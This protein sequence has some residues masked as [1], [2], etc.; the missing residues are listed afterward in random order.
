ME[1]TITLWRELPR[2]VIFTLVSTNQHLVIW[3][4]VNE[5]NNYSMIT[6]HISNHQTLQ[7]VIVHSTMWLAGVVCAMHS[8]ILCW[9]LSIVSEFW[10]STI[11]NCAEWF[12][13]LFQGVVEYSLCLFFAKLVSYTF[14]FW[15]P[16]YLENTSKSKCRSHCHNIVIFISIIIITVT[17]SLSSP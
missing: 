14:L 12:N 6:N 9:L 1:W 7:S 16:F 4:N 5:G 3:C 17:L 2:R 8:Q 11:F 13:L 10:N 15:L